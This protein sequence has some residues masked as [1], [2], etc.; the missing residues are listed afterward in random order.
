M[1]KAKY[2][3]L[4]PKEHGAWAILLIPYCIGIAITNEFSMRTILG[5]FGILLLF[6]SR[7]SLI[8]LVRRRNNNSQNILL[9]LNF[10][11][12]A[13][14]GLSIF[15][16][17][18]VRSGLWEL[19]YFGFA[20]LML[21]AIYTWLTLQHKERSVFGE[22][23]GIFLLTLS[24]P[25]A[26]YLA[27]EQL[28]GQAFVL[29]LVNTLYFASSVFYIKTKIKVFIRHANFDS[30]VTKFVLAKNFL[31]YLTI[32]ILII[33]LLTVRQ[34]IPLLVTLAFVPMIAH[35]LWSIFTRSP[36]FAIMK[37]GF[38]QIGLSFIFAIL[39]IISFKI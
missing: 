33:A 25:L 38:I 7:P 26:V 27:R 22:L 23:V 34:M 14:L 1:T 31:A 9:W 4:I 15:S 12:P 17:L 32:L 13:T 11:I 18:F 29:W 28:S 36:K 2:K 20:G 3:I 8:K 10:L 16:L 37:E 6:I 19:L 39:L 35:T 5:L 24:A 21:L 30:D